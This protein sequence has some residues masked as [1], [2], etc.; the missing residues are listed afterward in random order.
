MGMPKHYNFLVNY[1]V[2]GS[3]AACSDDLPEW[4]C[5][6]LGREQWTEVVEDR[7]YLQGKP[8]NFS[9]PQKVDIGKGWTL[10]VAPGEEHWAAG[11]FGR[12]GM[13]ATAIK[14]DSKVVYGLNCSEYSNV[15]EVEMV[16]FSSDKKALQE[17][18]DDLLPGVQIEN[19]VTITH[20]L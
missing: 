6:V 1:A 15:G 8:C 3:T 2:Q 7:L 5:Q 18:V 12:H 10:E 11:K 9:P 20:W 4:E 13:T 17:F 14:K 19:N 16:Y